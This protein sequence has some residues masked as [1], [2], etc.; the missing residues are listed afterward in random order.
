MASAAAKTLGILGYKD[1]VPKLIDALKSPDIELRYESIKA[2]GLI[3]EPEAGETL[4]AMLKNKSD[5]GA[6]T[7]DGH[8]Q[9]CAVIEA[10][11]NIAL[12]RKYGVLKLI[13][14]QLTGGRS[15]IESASELSVSYYAAQALKKLTVDYPQEEGGENKPANKLPDGSLTGSVE[16]VKKTIDAWITWWN[17]NRPEIEKKSNE[18]NAPPV[19]EGPIGPPAPPTPPAPPAPPTPPETPKQP[20]QPPVPQT[21]Q[22]PKT[23]PA[24]PEPPKAPPTQPSDKK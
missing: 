21:P 22:E 2:L 5:Y 1:A 9:I 12:K 10:L 6:K 16:T 14:E 7:L 8:S 13:G 3:G 11:G 4:A 15:D 17:R 20:E 24:P 23:P 19:P 18:E